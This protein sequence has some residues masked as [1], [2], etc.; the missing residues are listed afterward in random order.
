[1]VNLHVAEEVH[2]RVRREIFEEKRCYGK[3]RQEWDQ[4]AAHE[5]AI[6][7][8]GRDMMDPMN[9][10]QSGCAGRDGG[11]SFLVLGIAIGSAIGV[12]FDNI[13]MG[14]CIAMLIG[15]MADLA[16]LKLR[17]NSHP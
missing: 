4:E 5:R 17:R 16:V 8:S 6:I 10:R 7:A 1:M 2:A 15:A 14:L 12:V 13:P 3:Q 11:S 9:P